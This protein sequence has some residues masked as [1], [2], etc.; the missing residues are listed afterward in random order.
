M[1]RI[2]KTRSGRQ[3]L[4][5]ALGMLTAALNGVQTAA[6]E[7]QVERTNLEAELKSV[8]LATD[9]AQNVATRL[10]DLLGL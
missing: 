6:E 10:A 2:K 9:R 5:E 8:S 1:F 7:L 4:E 3:R